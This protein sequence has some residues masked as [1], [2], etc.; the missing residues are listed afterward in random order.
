VTPRPAAVRRPDRSAARSSAHPRRRA[1]R[2]QAR[3]LGARH[4]GGGR[5]GRE[6]RF[7]P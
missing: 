4:P 5:P 1:A 7:G 3:R 2:P 6:T